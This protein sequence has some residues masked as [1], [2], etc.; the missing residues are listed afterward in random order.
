LRCAESAVDVPLGHFFA[1]ETVCFLG[2]SG[3]LSDPDSAIGRAA[4]KLLHRALEGLRYGLQPVIVI[5]SRLGGVVGRVG[6]R[7]PPAG[8][9]LLVRVAHE[10]RRF[11][12]RAEHARRL[13]M[14]DRA[15][16]EGFDWQ[17]DRLSGIEPM[18]EE[19]LKGAPPALLRRLDRTPDRDLSD[20]LIT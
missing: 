15:D 12:R 4:L 11:L 19:Y 1:A 14:D 3:Y 16:E 20:I 8:H 17:V 2:F 13:F 7:K 6:G 18:L 10:T 9:P 5:E